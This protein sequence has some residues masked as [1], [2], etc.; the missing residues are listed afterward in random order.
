MKEFSNFL[1]SLPEHLDLDFM[2]KL[3]KRRGALVLFGGA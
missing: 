1:G 2:V 3:M